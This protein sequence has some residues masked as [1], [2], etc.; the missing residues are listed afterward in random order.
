MQGTLLCNLSVFDKLLK[1]N[2]MLKNKFWRQVL[3]IYLKW[4]NWFSSRT[5]INCSNIWKSK[6]TFPCFLW[7]CGLL[8]LMVICDVV[9]YCG[10]VFI[11]LWFLLAVDNIAIEVETWKTTQPQTPGRHP[12]LCHVRLCSY[13]NGT[14]QSSDLGPPNSWY[15]QPLRSKTFWNITK[16]FS[17]RVF[18]CSP[19]IGQH[20]TI[21]NSDWSR[22]NNT[23]LWL[24]KTK[25]YSSLLG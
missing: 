24:V 15:T 13:L 1:W 8:Q 25:Q 14:Q 3:P 18:K 2:K 23:Q 12:Q 10:T 20:K 5:S 16:C 7:G 6:M 11:W 4:N 22:Q 9:L 21:L 19:L 17:K